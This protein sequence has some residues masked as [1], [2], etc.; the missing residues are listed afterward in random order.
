MALAL[1]R[2]GRFTYSDYL[3]WPDTERWELIDGVAYNMVPA[4]TTTHQRLSMQLSGQLFKQLQGHRCEVFAAPFDVRLPR[5]DEADE[6]IDTVV[7]PDIVVLCDPSRLD[8]RGC[9]GA[10]DFIIEITSRSSVSRDSIQK[11]HLYER[12]G[13]K[14]YWIVHA[15]DRLVYIRRLQ[16]SGTFGP[17]DVQAPPASVEVQAVP[18]LVVN[19]DELFSVVQ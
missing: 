16:E 3:T 18:G 1:E 17:T 10:P 11:V 4:P 8:E 5:G 13:V 7:Q 9:R 19:L 15:A 12:H 14:E 2:E 6:L